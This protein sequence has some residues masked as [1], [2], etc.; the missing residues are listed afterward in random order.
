M[1]YLTFNNLAAA[2][3]SF[4]KSL[5]ESLGVS[6]SS[7]H[8]FLSYRR[9]DRTLVTSVVKFLKSIGT[10]IYIDYLDTTLEDKTN[11]AVAQTLRSR[12]SGCEKF[13]SLGTPNSGKSKWMPWELGLGDR[14]INYKNVVLLPVTHSPQE[15]SDQE[16]KSLYAYIAKDDNIFGNESSKW[17]VKYP[18]GSRV[19]FYA[20]L[21]S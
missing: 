3:L 5:N 6:P 16:Y 13:I 21:N 14:I 12:I 20:W 1:S 15:W 7:T 2:P 19:N 11:E 18:D 8:V 4:S 10:S 9:E 17:F